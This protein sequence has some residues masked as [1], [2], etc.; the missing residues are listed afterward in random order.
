MTA[1]GVIIR[2][3]QGAQVDDQVSRGAQG[4][5]VVLAQDPAAAVQGVLGQV[6]GFGVATQPLERPVEVVCDRQHVLVV[7]ARAGRA[8]AGADRCAAD[9]GRRA[10]IE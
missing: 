2:L 8:T 10:H 1:S 6:A 4:A 9:V 3:A 7:L 5:G